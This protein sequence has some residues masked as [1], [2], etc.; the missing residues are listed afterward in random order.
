VLLRLPQASTARRGVFAFIC[1]LMTVAFA[2]GPPSSASATAPPTADLV[3]TLTVGGI[4]TPGGAMFYTI[5]VANNGPEA[6]SKAV[7][8]DPTPS[9]LRLRPTTFYCVGG[10][11]PAGNPW[12]GPLPSTVLCTAPKAGSP[13]PSAARRAR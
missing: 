2:A 13:G 1:A 9:S 11:A 7:I 10:V 6:A 5:K 3:T 4:A 12:C 8:T